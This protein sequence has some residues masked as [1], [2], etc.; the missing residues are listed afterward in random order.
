MSSLAPNQIDPSQQGLIVDVRTRDEFAREAI[1]QSINIPLDEVTRHVSQLQAMPQ[2][3]LSCRS[4]RR[5]QE[6]MQTLSGFGVQNMVLLE[7]GIEGWKSQGKPVDC[8]KSGLSVMRQV[9]LVV[10]TMILVGTFVP[11]LWFLSLI[12]G[13]GLLIAGLTGTCMLASILGAMPWNRIAEKGACS[14]T[15]HS[16]GSCCG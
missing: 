8:R 9:Q 2:V 6:A 15:P 4:G 1:P 12:A 5:A 14:T 10:G 16:G 13:A 3:I 7:G 11:S